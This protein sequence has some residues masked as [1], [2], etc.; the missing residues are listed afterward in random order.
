M[1]LG[2]NLVVRAMASHEGTP[3]V[4][5]FPVYRVERPWP[6]RR[7]AI[8]SEAFNGEHFLLSAFHTVTQ[9]DSIVALRAQRL[10]LDRFSVC[11]AV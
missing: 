1:R 5:R 2:E 3:L 8:V 10:I 9:R 7:P 4:A 11:G 6:S